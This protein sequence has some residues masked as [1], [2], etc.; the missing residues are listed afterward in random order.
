MTLSRNRCVA[1][2]ALLVFLTTFGCGDDGTN[3]P[4]PDQ[5]FPVPDF[6]LVDVN[7]ASERAGQ[8][9]SPRDYLGKVSAWYFGAAT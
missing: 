2:A 9:V 5:S 8:V 4:A 1:L 6:D 3:G 7:P